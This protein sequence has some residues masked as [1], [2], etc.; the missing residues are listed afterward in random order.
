MK[1]NLMT[2]TILSCLLAIGKFWELY[3]NKRLLFFFFIWN[4]KFFFRLNKAIFTGQ[5]EAAAQC[6]GCSGTSCDPNNLQNCGNPL[7]NWCQ[8]TRLYLFI[9]NFDPN[10]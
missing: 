6:Y 2:I 1:M 3:L 10:R 7:T 5:A 8:V 4:L 9:F